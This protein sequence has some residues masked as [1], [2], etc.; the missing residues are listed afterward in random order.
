[1]KYQRLVQPRKKQRRIGEAQ[2]HELGIGHPNRPIET[3]ADFGQVYPTDSNAMLGNVSS[4]LPQILTIL[5]FRQRSFHNQKGSRS[6]RSQRLAKGWSDARSNKMRSERS[7]R[8]RG[9]RSLRLTASLFLRWLD[10]VD[11]TT[12]L[13]TVASFRQGSK[14]EI[15]LCADSLPNRRFIFVICSASCKVD[16]AGT[17]VLIFEL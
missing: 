7:R 5:Q 8:S 14:K 11:P 9:L 13:S 17:H 10:H 15:A 3:T 16:E 2:D 4:S 12:L 6:C 1:M